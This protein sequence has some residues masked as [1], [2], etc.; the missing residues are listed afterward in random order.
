MEVWEDE[1]EE[2]RKEGDGKQ[3][4]VKSNFGWVEKK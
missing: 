4:E 2:E 1:E 3:A